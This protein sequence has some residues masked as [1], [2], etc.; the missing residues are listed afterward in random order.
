MSREAGFPVAPA[1]GGD[2]AFVPHW[3]WLRA[4]ASRLHETRAWPSA[5]PWLLARLAS[6]SLSPIAGAPVLFILRLDPS[7]QISQKFENGL[8]T[9]GDNIWRRN[10]ERVAAKREAF[11]S[12]ESA[13]FLW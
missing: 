11:Q 5:S 4:C 9:L 8:G 7:S 13:E 2:L 3:P 6:F 12:R 10:L 1:F